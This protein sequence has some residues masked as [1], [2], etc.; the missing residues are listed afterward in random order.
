[1]DTTPTMK[2]AVLEQRGRAVVLRDHPRPVPAPGEAVL[3]VHAAG[4][5]RVDLYMRDNG[6]GITHQLPLVLGVEA[7]GVVADAPEGA[8][9]TARKRSPNACSR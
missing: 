3:R 1:M 8:S 2:A 6:A 4:L 7:A 5:N 9:T